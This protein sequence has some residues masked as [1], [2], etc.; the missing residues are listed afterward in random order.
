MPGLSSVAAGGGRRGGL[1]LDAVG[2]K[3]GYL[4]ARDEKSRF[5]ARKMR[6]LPGAALLKRRT[7][8][9]AAA[10]WLVRKGGKET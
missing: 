2:G 9:H 3:A 7:A 1:N 6:K 10:A 8:D 5:T 4:A